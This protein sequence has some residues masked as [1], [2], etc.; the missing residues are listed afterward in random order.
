MRNGSETDIARLPQTQTYDNITTRLGIDQYVL[1]ATM[2]IAIYQGLISPPANSSSA[3]TGSSCSTGNCTFPAFST[4]A[5]CHYCS[6]ISDTIIHT[7]TSYRLPSGLAPPLDNIGSPFST[8]I[9]EYEY[10]QVTGFEA[11]VRRNWYLDLDSVNSTDHP[12]AAYNCTLVPCLKTFEANVSNGLYYEQ[13]ISRQDLYFAG[14]EVQT[15]GPW[16]YELESRVVD[17][18]ITGGPYNAS[19]IAV[20]STLVN[21]NW[22]PCNPTPMN[23]TT[24]TYQINTTTMGIVSDMLDNT[25]STLWYP[26]SCVWVLGPQ[27]GFALGRFLGGFFDNNSLQVDGDVVHG[28]IWL[29]NLFNNGSITL[30]TVDA[31]MDG[32]DWTIT[33]AMR[34][35]SPDRPE[36]ATVTGVAHTLESCLAV[37]WAWISLPAALLA[38]EVLFLVAIMAMTRRAGSP[39]AA[40]GGRWWSEDW[41]NSSLALVFLGLDKT[42]L[43]GKLG[44]GHADEDRG[45]ELSRQADMY[46][47]AERIHVK[48]GKDG[49]GWRLEEAVQ[50]K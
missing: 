13:E 7:N 24:N 17:Q 10:A 40:G 43:G 30:D 34:Q 45:E 21:G 8:S 35:N 18:G 28:D 27:A 19:S 50:T 31:F 16:I 39:R 37:Q 47:A 29:M 46:R 25:T 49:D 1:D 36:L 23:T 12:Y 4:L 22:E 9:Q 14:W 44:P 48:L 15:G 6:D 42:I 32:L 2:Q 20:N 3:V 33:A 41:K 26:D 5:M 38:M 11:L